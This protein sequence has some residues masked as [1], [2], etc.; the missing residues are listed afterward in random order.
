[1]R[2]AQSGLRGVISIRFGRARLWLTEQQQAL[3]RL[4]RLP[5][6]YEAKKQASELEDRGLLLEQMKNWHTEIGY[7]VKLEFL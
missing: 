7:Q 2:F 6:N 5:T 3:G 4:N 1:M